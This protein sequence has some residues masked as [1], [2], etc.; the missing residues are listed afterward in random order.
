MSKHEKK[1]VPF[2]SIQVPF[3][4]RKALDQ[5][6]VIYLAELYESGATVAPLEVMPAEEEGKYDLT[7]GRHRLAAHDMLGLKT[8]DVVVIPRMEK[9]DALAHSLAANVGGS[10]P[11]T[12]E[13]YYFVIEQ[14]LGEGVAYSKIA[15]LLPIPKSMAMKYVKRVSSD[16]SK[17]RLSKAATAITDGA[18]TVPAAA[19]KFDVDEEELRS[20]LSGR[21]KR[22][23]NVAT[24]KGEIARRM[25]TTSIGNAATIKKAISQVDDGV[26]SQ[27]G[28]M[29]IFE[30]WEHSISQMTKS[31]VEW[32]K[33]A[34][35]RTA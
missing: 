34:A 11:P 7:D 14:L 2:E 6:L 32:K 24:M 17:K 15:G 19:K 21:K 20:M 25:K 3:Y 29:S 13:D 23:A 31:M 5:D 8:V 22:R 18:I 28:L 1:T 10:K 27:N 35:A 30:H 12:R 16:I 26:L 33:R 4:V 9:V